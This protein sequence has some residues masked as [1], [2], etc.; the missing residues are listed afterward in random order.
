M[1]IKCLKCEEMQSKTAY[2]DDWNVCDDCYE[3]MLKGI[4]ELKALYN[5]GSKTKGESRDG[6]L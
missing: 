6:L 3:E 5:N 4:E 2:P 1:K